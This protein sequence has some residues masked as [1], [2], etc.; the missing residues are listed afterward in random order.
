MHYAVATN[1]FPGFRPGLIDWLNLDSKT[2]TGLSIHSPI[3]RDQP[4]PQRHLTWYSNQTNTLFALRCLALQKS[5]WISRS[6][7]ATFW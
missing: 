6:R 2:A 3:S 1:L 5:K 4:D 7:K